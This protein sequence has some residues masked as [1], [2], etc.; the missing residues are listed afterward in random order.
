[1]NE[2]KFRLFI[3]NTL[4]QASYRWPAR[5]EAQRSSRIAPACFKCSCCGDGIYTGKKTLEKANIQLSSD[6]TIRTGKIKIDHIE[7]IVPLSGWDS[8]D[9][10]IN[11]L[12]CKAEGFQILCQECHKIKT[13][14]ENTERRKNKE[15]K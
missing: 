13:D 14:E 1:M 10:F 5:A 8:W 12:F 3:I 2:S 15:R 7:P 9:G 11:R 4:R 6:I